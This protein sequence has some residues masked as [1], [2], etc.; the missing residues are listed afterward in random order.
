MGKGLVEEIYFD[1]EKH[2]NN[3][4]KI[5]TNH[6][7]MTGTLAE[8]GSEKKDEDC[9]VV[10]LSDAKMWRLKDICTCQASDCNC[11]DANFIHFDELHVNVSKIIAF[12]LAK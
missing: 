9:H 12:S 3:K 4:I 5:I 2:G 6:L 1:A 8:C 7:K 11:N 10:T